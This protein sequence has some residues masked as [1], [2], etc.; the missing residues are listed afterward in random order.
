MDIMLDASKIKTIL[1]HIHQN[2]E[3]VSK[4]NNSI[5]MIATKL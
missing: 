1:L 4:K 2:P 5:A 3:I